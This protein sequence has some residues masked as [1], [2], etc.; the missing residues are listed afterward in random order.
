MLQSKKPNYQIA[1]AVAVSSTTINTGQDEGEIL[2][3]KK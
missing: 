2:T 3:A 1:P